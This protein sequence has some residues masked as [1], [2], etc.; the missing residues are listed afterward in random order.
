MPT[1]ITD[2]SN[3]MENSAS[4]AVPRQSG[5]MQADAGISWYENEVPAFVEA[6]LERLYGSLFSSLAHFRIYGGAEEASTYVVRHDGAP[7]VVLL[8][9]REPGAVR[10]IN[11][12]IRIEPE[13]IVRFATQIFG[14]YPSIARIIWH[15]LDI[16]RFS[17]PFPFHRYPCTD[18]SIV[19]LPATADEYLAQLGK[20][21]RKNI[22]R[23]QRRLVECFPSFH[24]Q[25]SER[26]QI[27]E[28]QAQA[29][30]ELNR[31]RRKRKHKTSG[32]DA[33][34]ADRMIRLAKE[35]GFAA[36]A[37]IDGKVCAGAL[38]FQF[39]KHYYSRVRAHD[40]QYDDYRLGLVGGYLLITECIARGGATLHFLAGGEKHKAILQGKHKDLHHLTLYRSRLHYLRESPAILKS[41]CKVRM[42]NIV[43][44]ARAAEAVNDS[45]DAMANGLIRV[46]RLARKFFA[47]T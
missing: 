25:I 23:Y 38:V 4:L 7:T 17:C 11:E 15:A 12:G 19:T 44:R 46:L 40:P 29:I 9:R 28:R 16:D 47:K 14:R 18:D 31:I 33:L 39:G 30:I 32:I 35:K 13:E 43:Q 1:T 3:A 21:T 42:R 36:V 8:F 20:P 5:A 2:A 34:E 22:R 26:D 37:T 41:E 24:Y 45:E 6:E 10:V 27:D